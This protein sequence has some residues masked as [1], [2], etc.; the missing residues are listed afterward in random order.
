M[1]A[2][3]EPHKIRLQLG[4]MRFRGSEQRMLQDTR[5]VGSGAIQGSKL[6][7]NY[8]DLANT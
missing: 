2:V 6:T 5:E 1:Q 4:E 3:L 8:E 7:M